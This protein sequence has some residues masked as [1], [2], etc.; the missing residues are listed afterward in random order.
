MQAL[1][2]TIPIEGIVPPQESPLLSTLQ[3]LP[4]RSLLHSNEGLQKSRT[5]SV[6]LPGTDPPFHIFILACMSA[7]CLCSEWC[8]QSGSYARTIC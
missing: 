6:P 7:E 2:D 8:Q 4:N 5:S 1:H 3:P